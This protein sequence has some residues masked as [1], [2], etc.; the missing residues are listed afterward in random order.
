MTPLHIYSNDKQQSIMR[1]LSSKLYRYRIDIMYTLFIVIILYILFHFIISLIQYQRENNSTNSMYLYYNSNDSYPIIEHILK[2][3]DD[4][5]NNLYPYFLSDNAM[6][7]TNVIVEFYAHWCY[8]VSNKKRK[9]V[10][11]SSIS[12]KTIIVFFF[13][14][15]NRI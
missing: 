6:K 11:E 13:Q 10:I 5:N 3:N 8:H 1:R 2:D 9:K 14:K 4:H 15:K 7:D 12:T